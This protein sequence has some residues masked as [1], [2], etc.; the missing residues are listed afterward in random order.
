[1]ANRFGGNTEEALANNVWH[2]AGPAVDIQPNTVMDIDCLGGDTFYQRYDHLK[3]YPY[4][5][6]DENQVIEIVSFMCESRVNIDGRC[7]LMRGL[8][9]NNN[10]SPEAF[11]S[12][13]KV[14]SQLDNYITGSY[15]KSTDLRTVKFPNTVIWSDRKLN[16]EQID[17]WTQILT[18]NSLDLDGDK[19]RLRALR[20][21][22]G[23]LWGFQDRAI[24]EILFNPNVAISTTD[25][26]PIELASSGKMEGKRYKFSNIGCSNKWSICE[27]PVGLFFNDDINKNLMVF[28]ESPQNLSDRMGMSTWAKRV[29][30]S[31]YS[32]NGEDWGNMTVQYDRKNKDVLY[33]TAGE[34]LAYSTL[35]G[36]FTSFY[37]YENTP[38]FINADNS[39]LGIRKF[40]IGG[41]D[42]T[43]L[44][45]QNLGLYG[46][47]F[48]ERQPF[49]TTFI[50]NDNPTMDKVFNTLEYRADYF[51][52]DGSYNK[53]KTFTRLF[54]WN[55]Y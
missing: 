39:T 55:E 22:A 5:Q 8:E 7:D 3:T 23:T 13:N 17:R 2:V 52:I 20:E 43:S 37:S 6:D 51:N 32:W 29:L 40:T 1:M 42:F 31:K 4:A 28:G 54:T 53:S 49:Y 50:V 47:F 18:T 33:I 46:D 9:S 45:Q 36:T 16:G 38:Y 27:T 26:S 19:G 25:G 44:W 15:I 11:N 21:Y 10:I 12:I 24:A 14:Y 41:Y 35:L 30:N 48:G 34:C